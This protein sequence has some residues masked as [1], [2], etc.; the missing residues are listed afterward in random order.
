[1]FPSKNP[2]DQI[3]TQKYGN[4]ALNI[5]KQHFHAKRTT[6]S[7]STTKNWPK[8]MFPSK[9]PHGQI[10][11]Q[12]YGNRALNIQKLHFHAKRTT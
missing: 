7:C 10:S 2:H 5:Q 3:S 1:M 4:R 12:K 6:E 9:N 8:T 11:T